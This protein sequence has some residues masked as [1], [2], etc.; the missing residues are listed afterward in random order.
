M[1]GTGRSATR[2]RPRRSITLRNTCFMPT[3]TCLR[4]RILTAYLRSQRLNFV[5]APRYQSHYVAAAAE[6]RAD[7][8][9]GLPVV[10]ASRAPG[11]SGDG[12]IARAPA[13]NLYRYLEA[14]T[15]QTSAPRAGPALPVLGLKSSA[16]PRL[17]LP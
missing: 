2:T 16:D 7:L 11:K 4:S 9:G 15:G 13:A 3:S 6:A 17:S 12:R 8:A 10:W 1:C 14:P 5:G